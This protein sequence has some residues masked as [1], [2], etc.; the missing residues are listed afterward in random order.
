LEP[1]RYRVQFTAGDEYVTLVEKAQAL[2]S[3]SAERIPLDELQLR[4]MR[5]FVA[6]LE[7]KK[8]ARTT[9]TAA[10]RATQKPADQAPP[11]A[12]KPQR[13][14]TA[15]ETPAEPNDSGETA[16]AGPEQPRRRGRQAPAAV[17]RA[18]FERDQG[19]C[20]MIDHI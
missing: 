20:L 14:R 19:R 5:T 13:P 17:R 15:Q 6:G 12:Q 7:R 1:E 4:A 8:R 16:G 2:L 3:H 18:V 10:A 11:T 9:R